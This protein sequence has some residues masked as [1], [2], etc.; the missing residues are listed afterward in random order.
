METVWEFIALLC[1]IFLGINAYQLSH[2]GVSPG[3]ISF[4]QELLL[5]LC[6]QSQGMVP[7]N[8]P[9]ELCRGEKE[10]KRQKKGRRGGIHRRL[11]NMSLND[12]H[13][14]PPLPT[15]LLSRE[16][17]HAFSLLRRHGSVKQIRT[18]CCH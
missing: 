3:R 16:K 1:V 9:P 17:T 5:S 4:S 6:P 10:R 11:R 8:I 14:L 18:R 12:R 2:H 7:G 13:K 15:I